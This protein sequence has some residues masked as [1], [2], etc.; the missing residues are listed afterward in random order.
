LISFATRH[1]LL[2]AQLS[3]LDN[4]I[5]ILLGP[6]DTIADAFFFDRLAR[7]LLKKNLLQLPLLQQILLPLLLHEHSPA[8]SLPLLSRH[9]ARTL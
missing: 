2:V 9:A 4:N 8:P 7:Q 1:I 5:L 6:P 3:V